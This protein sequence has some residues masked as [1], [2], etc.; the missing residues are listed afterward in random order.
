MVQITRDTLKEGVPIEGA[1]HVWLEREPSTSL[2]IQQTGV[3]SY[4]QAL[5]FTAMLVR[6]SADARAGRRARK[7]LVMDI[8]GQ[9]FEEAASA[10]TLYRVGCEDREADASLVLELG[11]FH[12][13][14][15]VSALVVPTELE[16]ITKALLRSNF[17]FAR[18]ARFVVQPAEYLLLVQQIAVLAGA[19]R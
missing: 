7:S 3:V 5:R 6:G 19:G 10:P 13:L 2:V 11:S 18:Q 8:A 9:L 16:L 1:L 14:V 4:V 15:L 17:L 12:P